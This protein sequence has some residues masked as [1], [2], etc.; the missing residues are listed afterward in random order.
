MGQPRGRTRPSNISMTSQIAKVLVAL[1]LVKAATSSAVHHTAPHHGYG[2][3]K[4]EYP[5]HNCTVE[6]VE[7]EGETCTPTFT[8]VCE[9]VTVVVKRIVDKEQCYPV[10]RT[11]CSESVEAVP[12]EICVYAYQAKEVPT[13][14][15]T[16]AVV[17]TT[18]CTTQMVTV[19]EPGYQ[20]YGG[21]G[22]DVHCKEVAEETCY[23]APTLEDDIQPQ[24]VQ[25]PE[26]IKQCVNKPIDLVVVSCE[27]LVEEKCIIV[28][29]VEVSEET[30]EVCRTELGEPDCNTVTLDLPKERCI[31]IVYGYAHGYESGHH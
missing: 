14:A 22:H 6:Q 3:P 13:E 16:V 21:Y 12:N 27:D 15:K 18:P 4:H 28:P 17:Y 9:P 25:F 20:P 5:K 7:E 31:E 10:T 8:T 11:V 26:P 19:C 23:N 24:T 29:E 30:H 1:F 2:H